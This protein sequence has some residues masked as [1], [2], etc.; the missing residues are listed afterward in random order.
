M[1]SDTHLPR[2]KLGNGFHTHPEDL[3]IT[4]FQFNIYFYEIQFTQ[5]SFTHFCRSLEEALVQ[6]HEINLLFLNF[7]GRMQ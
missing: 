3:E 5:N 7:Q 2:C 6:Q 4:F 1:S